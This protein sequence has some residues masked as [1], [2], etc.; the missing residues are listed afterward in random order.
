MIKERMREL[1]IT[2]KELAD[3]LG[4]TRRSI[5]N[6]LQRKTLFKQTELRKLKRILWSGV[7]IKIT[8]DTIWGAED[9][10]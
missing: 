6:K 5:I 7:K 10:G 8:N 3:K 9:E 2:Q 1:G 4:I